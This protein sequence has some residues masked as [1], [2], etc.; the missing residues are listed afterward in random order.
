MALLCNKI[1]PI[2]NYFQNA[3]KTK[4]KKI[5]TSSD[6][7]FA[8]IMHIIHPFSKDLNIQDYL[9]IYDN[10]S[11]CPEIFENSDLFPLLDKINNLSHAKNNFGNDSI[12]YGLQ[13]ILT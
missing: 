9:H 11:K 1:G 12:F 8:S 10:A 4:L 2:T 13:G 6:N 7:K 5:S 3:L